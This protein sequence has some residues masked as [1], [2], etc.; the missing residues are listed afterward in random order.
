MFFI[1]PLVESLTTNTQQNSNENENN[2]SVD[3]V[4]NAA[5]SVEIGGMFNFVYFYCVVFNRRM[6]ISI[7][8]FDIF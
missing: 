8:S 1:D 4:A 3:E 5:Q 7:D 6:K 2:G